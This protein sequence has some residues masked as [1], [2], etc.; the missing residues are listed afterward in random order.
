MFHDQPHNPNPCK[1][2]SDFAK[3]MTGK[4]IVVFG[5]LTLFADYN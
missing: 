2:L 1:A 3:I 4:I 5:L